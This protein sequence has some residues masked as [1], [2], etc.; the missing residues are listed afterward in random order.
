MTRF[1]AK[2]ADDKRDCWEWI[3]STSPPSGYGQINID[4]RLH[5]AHRVS[6]TLFRGPIPKGAYVCHRCDNPRCV[7]PDHLFLGSQ[8]DNIGDAVSKRRNARHKLDEGAVIEI[9]RLYAEGL[10]QEAIGKLHGIDHTMVSRI[11]LRKAWAHI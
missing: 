8:R 11:I 5:L 10:T 9:R 7:R 2:I 3:G 1:W 4:R 6:W